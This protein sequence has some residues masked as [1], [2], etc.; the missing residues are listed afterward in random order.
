MTLPGQEAV[1]RLIQNES[2]F[3]E[4]LNDPEN[5][6][7]R[8]NVTVE[9]VPHLMGRLEDLTNAGNFNFNHSNTYPQESCGLALQGLLNAM[10]APFNAKGD[11]ITDDSAA[12]SALFATGKPWFIPHTPNGFLINQELKIVSDGICQGQIKVK[13]GYAGVAIR[14]V[15][16][17]YGRKLAIYGLNVYSSDVRPNPYN[18]AKTVGILV[19]PSS[20]YSGNTPCPGVTLYNCKSTRFSINLQISTFNV[21]VISGVYNQGDHNILIFAYDTTYN[22]IN[23]VALM[24]VQADSS[25]TN[26]GN[27]AYGLRV[28]TVGNNVYTPDA[29]QGVNLRITGCNF[30]GSPVYI[31][32]CFGVNYQSNYHEQGAGYT[33]KGG[34]LILG[35]SGASYL[36]NVNV[37]RCWFTQFDYAIVL[38]NGVPNLDIGRNSYASIKYCALQSNSTESQNFTYKNGAQLGSTPSWGSS[39]Y[40]EVQTNYNSGVSQNQ[41]T[42]N[43]L[44]ISSDFL[45]SGSQMA[46][47]QGDCTNWYPY[48]MTQDGWQQLSSSVGRFRSGSAVQSNISC[49]QSG[50]LLT[51]VTP[52]QAALFNGGDIITSNVGSSTFIKSVNHASGTA[53]TNGNYNGAVT[54]SHTPAYFVGYNLSGFG[55]PNST[56]SANPGSRYINVAGGASATLYIKETGVGNT[57]WIAK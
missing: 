19:G 21:S 48:G 57:G 50:N 51:F 33:Y 44:S 23:D 7:T 30:D 12:L 43:G 3:D 46:P 41:L 18:S 1:D 38:I 37:D 27:V 28:G 45:I 8:T 11:G 17:T 29:N 56:V 47:R 31:D 6:T 32:N 14:I 4:F 9:S 25:A 2:R 5:Y 35:S 36:R 24:D 55:N 40:S 54:I 20:E 16:S 52:S 49:V 10:N 13:T 34:A 26:Y 39:G 22:Q 42:F 53:I 15:N